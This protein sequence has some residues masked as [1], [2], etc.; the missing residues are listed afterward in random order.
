MTADGT[1]TVEGAA[2]RRRHRFKDLRRHLRYYAAL[3]FIAVCSRLP[4]GVARRLGRA[5]GLLGWVF[6]VKE[7]RRAMENLEAAF[8][9]EKSR[10]E[11]SRICRGVFRNTATNVLELLVIHRWSREKIRKNFPL[12]EDFRKMEAALSGKGTVGVTGH[13]GNWELLGIIWAAYLPGRLVPMAKRI[14][15]K[16][17]QDLVDRFRRLIGLEVIYTD[18]SPRRLLEAL[19]AEKVLGLL[20][21]QDL[22]TA[23]GV[24]VDFFGRPAYT[25]TMPAHLAL[26]TGSH[27]MACSLVREGAGFRILFHMIPVADSGRRDEDL[28]ENTRR[29][30]RILE[31]DIRLHVDQWVWFHRRWRTRPEDGPRLKGRRRKLRHSAAE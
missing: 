5:A 25:S 27:F 23:N 1:S 31:D 26:A 9:K 15:F 30:T 22:K 4:L 3:P 21:D 6:A 8:G 20:P 29:W 24:F 14:Y 2:G 10:K 13:F 7:R 12:D 28:M 11:L 17:Y 16:K 18:E 19:R